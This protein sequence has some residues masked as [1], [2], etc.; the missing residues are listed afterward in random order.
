M[1]T[2]VADP[3]GLTG[4]VQDIM[5]TEVHTTPV[6]TPIRVVADTMAEYNLPRIIIV[7]EHRHVVGV[8]SQR[9]IL[10]H[11]L[12]GQDD[13]VA[14]QEAAADVLDAAPIETLITKHEPITVL[15]NSPLLKTA[16]VLATNKIGCLPVVGVEHELQGMLS[17]T[18]LLQHVTGHMR[19]GVE[20]GF[21]FY[22]PNGASKAKA[23]AFFRR[24]NGDLVIPLACVEDK[25]V[26][27]DF[28]LLGF[29]PS[30]GRILVKFISEDEH[31][32]TD[33]AIKGKRDDENVVVRAS[34]FVSQFN[35]ANK[36]KVFDVAAQEGG[37]YLVL[38]PRR[39]AQTVLEPVAQ[40]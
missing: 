7:D 11:F 37:R 40:S 23:P 25:S 20:T 19:Q 1:H 6:G 21:Q 15:P 34:G 24:A 16:F 18:D 30:R 13:A 27:T 35:L 8:I 26:L 28:V 33:G 2:L 12:L 3:R 5:T 29:D 36:A 22:S 10:R 4:V 17:T 39:V 14:D 32:E 31:A 9:D 38:T